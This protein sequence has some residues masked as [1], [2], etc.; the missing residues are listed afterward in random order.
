MLYPF[1]AVLQLWHLGRAAHSSYLPAGQRIIAPSA[2]TI[3]GANFNSD[4]TFAADGSKM[5]YEE[6]RAIETAEIP[7]LVEEFRSAAAFAKDAG[8]GEWGGFAAQSKQCR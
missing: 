2:L 6:P 7:A 8:F 5:P 4:G 3:D 1:Q